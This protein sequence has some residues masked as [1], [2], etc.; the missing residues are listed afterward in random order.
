MNGMRNGVG[1]R[2]R[3]GTLAAAAGLAALA[4]SAAANPYVG[5]W[6]LTLPNGRAGWLGIEAKAGAL[7]GSILWGGGSVV[8]VSEVSVADGVLI[9]TRIHPVKKAGADVPG[10]R[11]VE[12][13]RGTLEGGVLR[14]T[15]QRTRA[16]GK[17]TPVE[18]FEGKRIPPLPPAPDLARVKFGSPVELLNGRDLSGWRTVDPGSPSGWS[19]RDGVL[20]NDAAQEEGQPKKRYANLRT[21]A[22]FEDCRL[23]FEFR[24]PEKGNS[25][26]YLR[27][28]YEVQVHDSFGAEPDSHG[29]GGVYSRITPSSN[30]SKPA[31]EW[32]SMVLTL[33]DRHITVE[34][35][36]VVIIDN[37]PLLGCTGGA[38]SSDE[39][40]PGPILLQGDHMSVDYRKMV[41]KPVVK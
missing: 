40:R 24:V 5:Y 34:L 29:C 28:I 6:A 22:E 21:E 12:T 36:G 38:L 8:P 7:Q 31:G 25:G 10:K 19:V 11:E 9:V 2:I 37:Q 1:R 16:D 14:M 41:L 4:A 13:L 26:V 32:Q 30:P 23:S 27:G 35:N 18:S 39:F 20:V 33:V 17:T 3:V 15:T